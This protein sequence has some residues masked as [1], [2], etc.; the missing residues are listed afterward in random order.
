M[1][2]LS[3]ILTSTLLFPV[4]S[5]AQLV[6]T[7][8]K[9]SVFICNDGTVWCAGNNDEGQLGNGTAVSESNTPVQAQG[10]SGVTEVSTFSQHNLALKNNGTVWTWGIND[11][12]QLGNGTAVSSNIP[13]PI[14]G[15]NDVV[16]VGAGKKHSIALKSNGTVWAWGSNQ[17]GQIGTPYYWAG[18]STPVPISGLSNIVDISAGYTHNL[19]IDSNGNVWGWGRNFEGQLG[20]NNT[21][22]IP[23][24]VLIPN[25]SNVRKVSCGRHFNLALKNDS[26]VWSW[27]TNSNSELGLVSPINT[28]IPNQIQSLSEIIWIEAGFFHSFAINKHGVT[29]GWG[30]NG[31]T[32]GCIGSA[33]NTPVIYYTP[34]VCTMHVSTTPIY[35]QHRF[36]IQYLED[37]TIRS[38]GEN[39]RGQLGNGTGLPSIPST[40]VTLPCISIVNVEETEKII[41]FQIKQGAAHGIFNATINLEEAEKVRYNI[42]TIH[43]Q[44]MQTH[45]LGTSNTHQFKIDLRSTSKGIYIL[46]IQVGEEMIARKL[47]HY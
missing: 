42:Y 28:K 37:G 6:T 36:S 13:I 34:E 3:V 23:Y 2:L 4:F 15:L 27:G 14:I 1:K 22:T 44:L 35:A 26:T 11:F 12:G 33:D 5:F 19:A 24:P 39:D 16:K 17:Y 45:E 38:W 7:L 25:L 47:V 21:D 9:H 30:Y 46:R 41:D 18:S 20:L 10:L 8:Q 29:Y 32:Y 40:Q 31:T 43:G